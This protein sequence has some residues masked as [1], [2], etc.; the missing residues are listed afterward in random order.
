M[1][2]MILLLG[3]LLAQISWG[4]E[5]S[6][7]PSAAGNNQAEESQDIL[8]Q[9][10]NLSLKYQRGKYLVYDCIDK[11]WVCTGEP[12]FDN[13]IDGREIAISE[14]YERLPCVPIMQFDEVKACQKVQTRLTD[15]AFTMRDCLSKE[16]REVSK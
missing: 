4:Q 16:M 1:Y 2:K 15:R 7:P 9:D 13:C 11:H 12:E 10:P 3:L 8:L 6:P 5:T 14:N